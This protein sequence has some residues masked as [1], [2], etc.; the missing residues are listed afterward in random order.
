[1]SARV[2][3]FLVSLALWWTGLPTQGLSAPDA[4]VAKLERVEIAGTPYFEEQAQDGSI[5]AHQPDE[6]PA[7][8][9]VDSG[10]DLSEL[11]PVQPLGVAPA[12]RSGWED[13]RSVRALVRRHPDGPQRPPDADR[14]A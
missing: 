13:S 4:A 9:H 10:A 11:I 12:R 8:Q 2:V 7:Q 5:K 6:P 14:I 1:M 3:I